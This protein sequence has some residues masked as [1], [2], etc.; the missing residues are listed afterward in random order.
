MIADKTAIPRGRQ[1]EARR[2]DQA[3][4][5]AAREVFVE[6]P[7]AKM[8]DVAVRAGV[9]QASLYRRYR[10]KS[11]LLNVVCA[12]GMH[13]IAAAAESA[14]DDSADPWEV[15]MAFMI[16]FVE[17]GAGAQLMLAGSFVPDESLFALARHVHELTQQVV[18]RA[19][20]AG[21]LRSDVTGPD[22]ALLAAQLCSL[23][24]PDRRRDHEF[25]RRYLALI[26][27]GLRAPAHGRLPGRAPDYS[28]L[29]ERWR[30]E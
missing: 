3:V 13:S 25:R 11:E 8:S 22:I 17:S 24:S 14:L 6:N 15:F 12:D 1:H 16:R 26:L 9:G 4:I 10:T 20:A 2:N 30:S 23:R 5:A 7:D 28:E 21:S 19:I 18:E 29:E 27:D